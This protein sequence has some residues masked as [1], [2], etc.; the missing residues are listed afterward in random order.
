MAKLNRNFMI[1]L[2]IVALGLNHALS[3]AGTSSDS[4]STSDDT[5]DESH[6]AVIGATSNKL[7]SPRTK[8]VPKIVVKKTENW[9]DSRSRMLEAMKEY[10]KKHERENKIRVWEIYKQLIYDAIK[11]DDNTQIEI[12]DDFVNT[13]LGIEIDNDL[14]NAFLESEDSNHPELFERLLNIIVMYDY[15]K[16][17]RTKA[18]ADLYLTGMG[19]DKDNNRIIKITTNWGMPPSSAVSD[20]IQKRNEEAMENKKQPSSESLNATNEGELIKIDEN[21]MSTTEKSLEKVENC[22]VEIHKQKIRE[23][24]DA[25]DYLVE[26]HEQELRK[27]QDALYRL[28]DGEPENGIEAIKG[29]SD[30]MGKVVEEKNREEINMNRF[31]H[32]LIHIFVIPE[33]QHPGIGKVIIEE[34]NNRKNH[35]TTKFSEKISKIKEK[36]VAKMTVNPESLL[37]EKA[38]EIKQELMASK[39]VADQ[40]VCG[41]VK[42][43]V[44]RKADEAIKEAINKRNFARKAQLTVMGLLNSKSISWKIKQKV[45]K[46]INDIEEENKEKER[47]ISEI[48]NRM[49]TYYTENPA[50]VERILEIA[51]ECLS[52]A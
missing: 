37:K 49:L 51:K 6:N 26:T 40:K 35:L 20:I 3:F 39:V 38:D 31:L 1:R 45:N 21:E 17:N 27:E 7:N 34:I 32:A 22:L 11:T 2:Y 10:D 18:I 13:F 4:T 29:F 9:R 33:S 50:S 23:E 47:A 5:N 43:D 28:M 14:V 48:L 41:M 44:N 19:I 25:F 52:D 24:Q 12:D 46:I 8:V 15:N 42:P 36:M 16:Q 30:F